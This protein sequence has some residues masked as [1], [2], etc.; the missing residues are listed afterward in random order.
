M[1]IQLFHTNSTITLLKEKSAD[2]VDQKIPAEAPEAASLN[3]ET[4]ED[5]KV[6]L[7]WK[8]VDGESTYGIYAAE[9]ADGNYV[10]IAE[11]TETSYTVDNLTAGNYYF[12]VA[13]L[14]ADD[15]HCVS[16]LVK[17]T[18]TVKEK[19]E[20]KPP[21]TPEKPD[22]TNQGGNGSS[23]D[24]ASQST[25]TDQ[26][27]AISYVVGENIVR[28]ATNTTNAVVSQETGAVEP[29]TVEA[30]N[31]KVPE[32][33]TDTEAKEETG[34]IAEEEVPLADTAV[35]ETSSLSTIWV[36][37]LVIILLCSGAAILGVMLRK[38]DEIE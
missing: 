8:A 36:V 17:I 29:E 19:E 14:P 31:A 13:A 12:A 27:T 3:A 37:A 4:T 28:N 21:V 33:E 22:D 2:S 35:E 6:T 20:P 11:T 9:K 25:S 18:V 23:F 32:T 1:R 38:K 26:T 30:E 10:L 5:G 7:R 34:E 16:E 15:A 24:Q